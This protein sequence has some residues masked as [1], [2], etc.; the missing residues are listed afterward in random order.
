MSM[1]LSLKTLR[2]VISIKERIETLERQLEKLLVG[3]A[4]STIGSA[5]ANN[6]RK[7]KRTMSAGHRAKLAEA[8]KARWKKAKAAGK[9]TL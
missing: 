8:A 3:G 7:R 6:G 9:T 2:R 5:R 4:T 1:H